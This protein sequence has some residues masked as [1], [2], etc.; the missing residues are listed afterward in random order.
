MKKLTIALTLFCFMGL[1]AEKISAIHAKAKGI[2]QP[3]NIQVLLEKDCN[4]ALLEVK[5]SYYIYNPQDGSKIASGILGKR[6]MVHALENGLKWGEYFPG[7]HQFL[8]MPRSEDSSILVNGIQYKGGVAVYHVEDKISIVN[9]VQIEDFIKSTLSPTFKTPL[10]SEA[11]AAVAIVARTN[12]Y[13]L[14]KE[15]KNKFWHIDAKS[16][17]YLGASMVQPNSEVDK[18][19]EDTSHLILM[20]ED[21]LPFSAK[22]T[23]HCAGKTAP[24]H[25]I[26]RKE[27]R[28]PKVGAES[29]TASYN[30]KDAAWNFQ[31]SKEK[32]SSLCNF[33]NIKEV[34]LFMDKASHKTYAIHL[35]NDQQEKTLDFFTLQQKIG[36]ELLESNDFTIAPKGDSILF[37]GYGSGDGVGLCLYTAEILS[38]KGEDA[39]SI[40]QKFYPQTHLINLSLASRDTNKMTVNK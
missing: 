9:N 32:L 18:A 35:K 33:P 1:F 16:A 12:A 3:E 26:Y 30:R 19:V 11:M 14:V 39:L 5:G 4:E 27:G 38:Q 31:I 13:H 7:I 34:N 8:I 28:A 20:N 23:E 2:N 21:L 36:S 10:D 6:F 25:I 15:N 24:Y 22:W 37:S 17:Q 40:L 29:T